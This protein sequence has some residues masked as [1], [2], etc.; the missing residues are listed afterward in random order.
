MDI[1]N[2]LPLHSN[3]KS[4]QDSIGQVSTKTH[5]SNISQEIFSKDLIEELDTLNVSTIVKE[6]TTSSN[7]DSASIKKEKVIIK[8]PSLISQGSTQSL[9]LPESNPTMKKFLSGFKR[10]QKTYF[11]QHH[12]LYDALKFRQTPKTL[13]VGCCDSR[14][15]PA[16]I[17]DCDP[18]DLFVVRN[19]GNLVAPY[20][21]DDNYHGVSAALEYAVKTLEV[22]IIIVLGHTHCGGIDA[23]MRG[24]LKDTEF[25]GNWMK[26]AAQAKERTLKYFGDQDY[27]IQK[28][29]CEHASILNSVENLFTYPWIREKLQQGKLTLSG[30]YFDFDSGDLLGYNPDSGS[31]E[32]LENRW[33]T[34]NKE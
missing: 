24:N 9:V 20:K 34:S 10:F 18:G 25:L 6:S 27:E 12:E 32:T 2:N 28:K 16:I 26:I 3:T 13:V 21:P 14:V 5:L 11:S 7:I 8:L 22:E 33:S 17:T 1:H 4:S 19:V 29:A 30:W 31:F 23:L 15:D